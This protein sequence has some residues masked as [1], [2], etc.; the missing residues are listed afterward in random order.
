MPS[1]PPGGGCREGMAFPEPHEEKIPMRSRWYRLTSYSLLLLLIFLLLPG[2][3]VEAASPEGF[4]DSTFRQLWGRSDLAV[5]NGR[6]NRSWIW[7]TAAAQRRYERF[8]QAPGMARLVQYFDKARMEIN[9]PAADRRSTWFVTSPLI[10]PAT[11]IV[12][13][14]DD[15]E[16]FRS[17]SLSLRPDQPLSVELPPGVVGPLHIGADGLRLVVP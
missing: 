11:Q 12:I 10:M 5:A 15:R 8:D 7:G 14:T 9:D 6:T 3:R 17:A 16:V 1:T 13:S 4:A 2:A